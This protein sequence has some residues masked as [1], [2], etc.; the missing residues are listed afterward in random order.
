[1]T[2]IQETSQSIL[3]ELP[4]G[5]RQPGQ[6]KRI[7]ILPAVREPTCFPRA[8]H[9][10]TD[11]DRTSEDVTIINTYRETFTR[12]YLSDLP[13]MGYWR[14]SPRL[15]DN[16]KTITPQNA[17][18][19]Y[20]D[21]T[22][23]LRMTEDNCRRTD[24]DNHRPH[25]ELAPFI[26]QFVQNPEGQP[27]LFDFLAKKEADFR[28]KHYRQLILKIG[29][30]EDVTNI[31]NQVPKHLRTGYLQEAMHHA[32]AW[33]MSFIHSTWTP[34][35]THADFIEC[36]KRLGP[37]LITGSFGPMFYQERPTVKDTIST[38]NIYGWSRG[39]QAKFSPSAHAIIAIGAA[40]L[41]NQEVVYYIDP[42]DGSDPQDKE[43]QRIY[44]ISYKSFK[45]RIEILFKGGSP[46]KTTYALHHVF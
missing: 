18:N 2:V 11:K 34:E 23:T 26:D 15:A 28:E 12:E 31:E 22:S 32:I 24:P 37:H 14:N 39:A 1:M 16:L 41:S 40:N 19:V 25:T 10:L 7:P 6:Q 33:K 35:Q 3:Y 4:P 5:A 13:C 17:K 45:E 27:T 21:T 8:I 9:L 30:P 44:V 20:T 42:F 38:R 29:S 43:V 36:L 46:P